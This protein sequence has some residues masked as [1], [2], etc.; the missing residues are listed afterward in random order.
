MVPSVPENSQDPATKP[1]LKLLV[2][3]RYVYRYN[4]IFSRNINEITNS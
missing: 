4:E 2:T 3:T 1:S